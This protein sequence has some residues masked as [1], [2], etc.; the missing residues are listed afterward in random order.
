MTSLRRAPFLAFLLLLGV[1]ALGLLASPARAGDAE[2]AAA[3]A[4]KLKTQ[5]LHDV[6]FEDVALKDVLVWLRTATGANFVIKHTALAKAGIDL[7]DVRVT[8][9]LEDVTP[10]TVLKLALEPHDL[11]LKIQGN[12]AYVTTRVDA[13][14]PPVTRIYTISHITWTKVDFIAPEINLHPSDY[15]PAEDYEPERIVEDD[16]LSTGDAV[17]ELLQ[18]LV[19][20]GEWDNEGWS[21]RATDRYIVVRAPRSVHALVDRALDIIASLK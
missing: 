4:N 20:P 9:T 11:A 13:M 1:G 18:D 12:V 3:L 2:R 15:A 6:R 7:E 21:M 16:P 14:G 5:R 19:A 17:A 8:L 10:A